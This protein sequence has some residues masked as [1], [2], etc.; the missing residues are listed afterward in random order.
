[1][2]K[3]DQ[4]NEG[5]ESWG[6]RLS[7]LSEASLR[8]NESLDLDTVLQE[9][10]DSARELTEA[11]YSLITTL[12]DSG[13]LKDYR[14][15]GMT[16]DEARRLWELPDGLRLF[17]RLS[18]LSGPLRVGDLADYVRS[19]GLPELRLPVPVYAVLAAPIRHQG[20]GVG[21]IYVSRSE[22][23]LAFSRE[24]EDTLVMFASQAALVIANA[25][26]HRDEQ[27]ARA[28]LETLIDTSPV[29]VVVFDAK[30]GAP[31]YINREIRRIVGDL[32][33]P[34]MEVEQLLSYLTFR[35]ADGRKVS[36]DELP[37][38][39]ALSAGETVRVEEIVLEVPDGRSL[40]TLVNATPVLSDDGVVESMVVTVQ[41][42]T[43]MEE[44]ERLRAEF[45]G[46]VS[47]ELRMPLTSIRGSA[48][49]LLDASSDMD[50]AE[51]RP[52]PPDH[53]RP[54]RQHAGADRRPAGRGPHR[55][56]NPADQP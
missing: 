53:R 52:V 17:E 46:M 47:H 56:R 7:R 27:L 8:I 11:P 12:D 37:L 30:T 28:D 18:D 36:L 41:D 49:A 15:S 4:R 54:G 20:R 34:G 13:Q 48:T 21:H 29:G 38:A 55:D 1:M 50:P 16:N 32:R 10:L 44:L 2:E 5:T 42:M 6:D 43:P 22:P 51:M 40:T 24:D 35:R 23:G 26:R 31:A 9:V 45:L 19:L 14:V 33:K 25:R 39:Q 3:A